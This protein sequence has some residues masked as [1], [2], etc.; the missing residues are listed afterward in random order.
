MVGFVH[1]LAGNTTGRGSL[2]PAAVVFRRAA[3][4]AAVIS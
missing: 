4:R 1:G 3:W 2:A